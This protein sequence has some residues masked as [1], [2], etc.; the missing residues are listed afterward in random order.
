M[1]F[2]ALKVFCDVAR[3][4]SFSQAATANQVTQSAVSQMIALMENRIGVQLIDRSTRPLQLTSLGKTYYDGC[5][6]IWEQYNELEASLQVFEIDGR[7]LAQ[8]ADDAGL[9]PEAPARRPEV[10]TNCPACPAKVHPFQQGSDDP[11]RGGP[12]PA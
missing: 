3:H 11:P 6:A 1:Q 7:S 10:D 9:P 4:R 2:E 8:R 12:F 5:K